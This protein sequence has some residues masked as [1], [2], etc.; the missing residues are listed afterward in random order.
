MK[1]S[2]KVV[3]S[4][5]ILTDITSA[6]VEHLSHIHL[7]VSSVFRKNEIR[8][9]RTKSVSNWNLQYVLNKNW[10]INELFN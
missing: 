5:R 3:C 4:I 9:L 2:H 8:L 10:T 1:N 6:A 7:L